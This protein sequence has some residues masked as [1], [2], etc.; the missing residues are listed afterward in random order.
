MSNV[1]RDRVGQTLDVY[2]VRQR[3]ADGILAAAQAGVSDVEDLAQEGLR[4][5]EL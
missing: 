3:I 4:A 2:R 5:L 1:E